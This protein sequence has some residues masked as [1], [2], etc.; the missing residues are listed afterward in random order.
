MTPGGFVV[1]IDL[2]TS[3]TVAVI[4]SP[5]GRRRPVLFDGAPL[6]PSSVFLQDNGQLAVGRDAQRLA[7]LDPGRY[8]PNPKRRIDEASVLLGSVEIPTVQV[9]AAVLRSVGNGISE[10]TRFPPPAVLTYPASWG[11]MRRSLLHDAAVAAGFPQVTLVPEPVAAARYFISALNHPLP[12]GSAMVVYDFGGGTIDIAVVRNDDQGFTVIGSG[13]LEDV[14]GLDID[15]ALV[16]LLGEVLRTS[17]PD[18]WRRLEQ[19]LT[20]QDRRDRRLFWEDIRGA[21]EMLSRQTVAPVSVPGVEAALHLTREE[22]ERKIGPM[23]RRTVAE[24]ARVVQQ[25]HLQ[26]DQLAGIMLVGGSSRVPLVARMLHRELQLAPTVLEQPELPVAEGAVVH[27]AELTT[28]GRFGVA[29]GSASV[30]GTAAAFGAPPPGTGYGPPSQGYGPPG[31]ASPAGYGPA[32]GQGSPSGY[33]PAAGYGPPTGQTAPGYGVPAGQASPGYGPQPGQTGPGHTAPGQTAPGYGP[34]GQT[35][36]GQTPPGQTAPGYGVP[37]GQASPAYGPPPGQGS[38]GG[39][40]PPP[41]QTGPGQTAPGY[42]G[43]TGQTGQ[44]AYGVPAQPASAEDLPTGQPLWGDREY[45]PAHVE[46]PITDPTGG[47]APSGYVSPPPGTESVQ[48]F[49]VP[50][51]PTP[52]GGIPAQ[53]GY[54]AAASAAPTSAPPVSGVP[55]SAPPVSGIPSSAPPMGGRSGVVYGGAAP[56]SSMPAIDAPVSGVPVSGPAGPAYPVTGAPVSPVSPAA[57]PVSPGAAVA[58]YAASPIATPRP[59]AS[60]DDPVVA[61]PKPPVVD[62][63]GGGK[64]RGALIAALVALVVLIG[65]GAWAWTALRDKSTDGGEETPDPIG[66]WTKLPDVPTALNGN[67]TG[68]EGAGAA[69]VKNKLYV[70]GGFTAQDPRQQINSVWVYDLS[71]GDTGKWTEGPDLPKPLSHMAVVVDRNDTLWVL[72]GWASDGATD[73]VIQLST[74]GRAWDQKAPLPEPRLSGAAVYDGLGIIFAGGTDKDGNATDTIYGLNKTGDGWDHVGN[75]QHPREKLAAVSDGAGNV[76]LIGGTYKSQELVYDDVEALANRK[77]K[78]TDLKLDHPREGPAGV[79]IQGIGLCVLGGNKGNDE[80]FDW[81]CQDASKTPLLPQLEMPRSG[82]ALA[83]SAGAVYAIGGYNG[84]KNLHGTSTV[85]VFR[86][87]K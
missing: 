64:R 21:K 47:G 63:G 76:L 71:Q 38:P 33:A 27:P 85:E 7:Q 18:V 55:F 4:R 66:A 82:I 49:H 26:P 19:P 81:W 83:T 23:I 22:L 37:A 3:N 2:G 41:G 84:A 35:G 15:A 67:K 17:E 54:G 24:T 36:S 62:P 80:Y 73:Q 9:L 86:P 48:Q 20:S 59:P 79:N 68:I 10:I 11:Q 43:Q 51:Q 28:D 72:G 1:G 50:T 58:G 45:R 13:G 56:V 65:G 69:V 87:N 44:T 61:P 60:P 42:G 40:G 5:D 77:P 57:A 8:E 74:D 16:E 78:G 53:T 31:Q 30:G 75:L 39:Y 12:R 6:M 14:G 70:I 46:Q 29:T 52:S 32:T 25:C 34:P